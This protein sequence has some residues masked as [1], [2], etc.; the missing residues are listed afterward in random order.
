[1]TGPPVAIQPNTLD[2]FDILDIDEYPIEN[3]QKY[4]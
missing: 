4:K 3:T 2:A 1:M